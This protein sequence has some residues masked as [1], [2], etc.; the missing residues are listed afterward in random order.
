M[1]ERVIRKQYKVCI[2]HNRIHM[3]LKAE[4]LAHEEQGKKKRRK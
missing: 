1:L 2:S 3:Y 4:R